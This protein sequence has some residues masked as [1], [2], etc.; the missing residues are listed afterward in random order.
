MKADGAVQME[1]HHDCDQMSEDFAQ[2]VLYD[3]NTEQSR[4]HGVEFAVCPRS[5]MQRR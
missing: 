5:R 3:G 1:S 2:C 4:P